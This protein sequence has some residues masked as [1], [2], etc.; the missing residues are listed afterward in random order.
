MPSLR[1]LYAFLL[2]LFTPLLALAQEAAEPLEPAQ[3]YEATRW[4]T[5]WLWLI[6][7]AIAVAALVAWGLSRGRYRRG[8]PVAR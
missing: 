7:L 6:V 1:A 3:P 8:P 4:G 2:S 5:G